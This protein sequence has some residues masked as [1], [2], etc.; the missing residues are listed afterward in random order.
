M[1][2]VGSERLFISGGI[3]FGRVVPDEVHESHNCSFAAV[4]G[5]GG[6]R[7]PLLGAPCVE[8]AERATMGPG[9]QEEKQ[10]SLDEG[11][12]E[13]LVY[14]GRTNT[15]IP[16]YHATEREKVLRG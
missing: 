10:G 14:L 13:V 15:H 7:M 1:R 9:R 4:H 12:K 11:M 3:D 5:G 6:V 8:K 2:I 16:C